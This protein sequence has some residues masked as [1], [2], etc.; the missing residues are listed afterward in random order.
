MVVAATITRTSGTR[1]VAVRLLAAISIVG[2]A[3]LS[4]AKVTASSET[5][6]DL[7]RRTHFHGIAFNNQGPA[8]LVVAT[9]VGVFSLNADGSTT[10]VSPARDFMGFR[11]HPNQAGV[12]YTSGRSAAGENQGFLRS[13]DGGQTWVRVSEGVAGPINFREIAV[14]AGDPAIIYGANDDIQMSRDGGL[15]WRMK[16]PVP[17]GLIDLAVSSSKTNMLFAATRNGLKASVDAGLSWNTVA[18][19]GEVV[20]V[21]SIDPDGTIYAFV[22]WRGLLRGIDPDLT[23][24]TLLNDRFGASIPT[25]LAIDPQDTAHLALTTHKNEVFESVDGGV[26]WRRVEIQGY[27]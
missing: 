16:G 2:A 3:L 17:D 9:H 26:V 5:L 7:A 12:F 1:H 13:T 10:R 18:F 4:T 27:D 23:E 8:R 25:H 19:D 20:S 21:L 14:S 6:A 22:R 15:T 11:S 24:W